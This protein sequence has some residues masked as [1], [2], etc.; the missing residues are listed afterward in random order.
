MRF[1]YGAK[2]SKMDFH[3]SVV[4]SNQ[5]LTKAQEFRVA[6]WKSQPSVWVWMGLQ[7]ISK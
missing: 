3:L 6:P 2:D 7:K 1:V 4:S 5:K